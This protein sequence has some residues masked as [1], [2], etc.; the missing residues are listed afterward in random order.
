METTMHTEKTQTL[1][2]CALRYLT[3]R[4]G[5]EGYDDEL[6]LVDALEQVGGYALLMDD[7]GD[8][9]LFFVGRTGLVH[10]FEPELTEVAA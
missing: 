8:T 9:H 3:H 10:I 2:I 5:N 1:R 4:T 6:R 7:E